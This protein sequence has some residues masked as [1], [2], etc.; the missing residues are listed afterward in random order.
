MSFFAVPLRSPDKT[1]ATVEQLSLVWFLSQ[2]LLT[3]FKLLFLI[4]SFSFLTLTLVLKSE[5]KVC[6]QCIQDK[7]ARRDTLG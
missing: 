2:S 1:E 7:L 5:A 6:L 4:R 3:A